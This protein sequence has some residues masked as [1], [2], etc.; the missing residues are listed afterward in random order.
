[1]GMRANSSRPAAV[2]PWATAGTWE[3]RISPR[4]IRLPNRKLKQVTT[5][6]PYSATRRLPSTPYRENSRVDSRA[7]PT[8]RGFSA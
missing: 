7:S 1:M 4:T 6:P 3:S 5:A 8:P 2:I